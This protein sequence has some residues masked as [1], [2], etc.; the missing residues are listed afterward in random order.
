MHGRCGVWMMW[1]MEGVS[2]GLRGT[3]EINVCKCNDYRVI[4]CGIISDNNPKIN[5]A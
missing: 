2:Y 4:V 3:M 5:V 1:C